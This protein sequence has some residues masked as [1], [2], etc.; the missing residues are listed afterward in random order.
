MEVK[1]IER[2]GADWQLG[3]RRRAAGGRAASRLRP[4]VADQGPR[5]RRSTRRSR[6][7]AAP[8]TSR[9]G[10]ACR[11]RCRVPCCRVTGTS[12]SRTI[13]GV[14]SQ[15]MLCSGDELGL[16]TDADGILIL[17]PDTPLGRAAR[18]P[19]RRRGA[20]RRRQ[21]QP[22]RRAVDDRPRARG[23]RRDRAA[24]CAGRTS[25]VP[26]TG[27]ATT[28][29]VCVEVQDQSAVPAVRGRATSTA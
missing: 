24:R 9:S 6:S 22:R 18:R 25:T 4:A 16:D 2:I 3:R 13:A 1:S 17:P 5:R 20:G 19:D 12:R 11:W 8:T 21:A 26:E 23:R 10:S 29:H 27:D 14:E 7:C 15:G 28:D